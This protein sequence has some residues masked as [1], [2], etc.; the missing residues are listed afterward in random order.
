MKTLNLNDTLAACLEK[1][2]QQQDISIEEGIE[3]VIAKNRELLQR[4]AS[5]VLPPNAIKPK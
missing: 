5:A 3:Y 4:L 2:A 1:Q